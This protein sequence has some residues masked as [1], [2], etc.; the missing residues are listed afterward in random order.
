[1][2]PGWLAIVMLKSQDGGGLAGSLATAGPGARIQ[3]L[4]QTPR[5]VAGWTPA[6]VNTISQEPPIFLQHSAP[7]CAVSRRGPR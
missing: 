2:S 7:G 6:L 1:M 5:Q 4:R 3:K